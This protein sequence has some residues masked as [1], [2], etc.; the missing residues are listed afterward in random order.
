[1]MVN[2]VRLRED[3]MIYINRYNFLRCLDH[4]VAEEVENA[5][6][7]AIT[8]TIIDPTSPSCLRLN[9]VEGEGYISFVVVDEFRHNMAES[10]LFYEAQSLPFPVEVEMKVQI[11]SKSKTKMDV[12]LKKQQLK[13][14]ANEQART[15]D[16]VDSSVS[17]SAYLVR[18]L[19]DEIKKMMC[20]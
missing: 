16:E 20:Q 18:H 17:A 19:Q 11:E 14:A 15:G 10:E 1:M 13:E 4:Q 5:S 12:N 6:V 8:N 7:D 3:E 2:G 9:G